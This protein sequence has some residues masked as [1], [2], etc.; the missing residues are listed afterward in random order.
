MTI[1]EA[2][3][4][5]ETAV[6]SDPISDDVLPLL[7][8][9]AV[10]R[11]RAFAI[12]DESSRERAM[13]MSA[14]VERP[15]C[16]P[17]ERLHQG[18]WPGMLAVARCMGVYP[19]GLLDMSSLVESACAIREFLKALTIQLT[20][21]RDRWNDSPPEVQRRRIEGYLLMRGD[22]KQHRLNGCVLRD[23]DELS[24]LTTAGWMEGRYHLA[25]N[26]EPMLAF[27]LPGASRIQLVTPLPSDAR[28]AWPLDFRRA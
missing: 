1:D 17:M 10:L 13:W 12:H 9:I 26:G 2:I 24:L 14:N 19:L 4:I 28:L 27:S 23:G 3:A 25:A 11:E 21:D 15:R 6:A 7:Q 20:H 16:E 18:P 5:I 8:A 22:E